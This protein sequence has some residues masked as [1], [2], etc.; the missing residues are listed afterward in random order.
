MIRDRIV[1]GLHDATL[2][3]KLQLEPELTLESAIAKVRQAEL[4]RKQQPVV[5]GDKPNIESVISRK[6][7]HSTR[8]TRDPSRL[9]TRNAPDKRWDVESCTR[10]GKVPGHNPQ[11][12]PAKL[13]TCHKCQKKG[14]FQKM[15]KTKKVEAVSTERN[16]EQVFLGAIESFSGKAWKVTLFVNDIPIQFKIDTGAEVSVIPEALSEPFSNILKPSNRTLSGP[17]KQEHHVCGQF[18]CSMRCDKES[19][20]Q[21]LYVVK[22]LDLA[23]V[24][25]PAIEA[26]NLV[27]KICNISTDKETIV[28]RFPKLFTGL[29]CLTEEYE[30][31]LSKDAVPHALTTPRRV[32]LPLLEPVKSELQRMEREGIITKVEGP[33]NWCAGMVV[34]P[35]PNHKV[36]I[37]VDLTHLNKSV[38]RE[39]HILPSVNHTLAQL[40]EAQFFTKLDANSGFWQVPLSKESARLTTFITPYG[41]FCFNRLPFGISSAPELFQRRMSTAL[42]GLEGV[43][44]LMDDI[45]I[46]GKTREEHD[47]RVLATLERLQKYGITLNKEKCSF[48]TDSVRFLGHIVRREG[49][50]ADPE[51]VR[52]I[53]DLAE[54]RN[55]IE[56]RRFLGM[57]NQLNKFS[58]LLTDTTKPMRDLLCSRNQWLWGETQPKAFMETKQL[59]SSTPIL[60]LYDQKRP[61]RVSA[62][63]SS[64]GL[65]A[66]LMQQ[67]SD[68]QWRPIAY[69]SRAMT[70]TEQR[71]AQV[72]KEA[73]AV[74][75]ACERFLHYLLGLPF[76]IE[77]D[78]KPLVSLLGNKPIDELPLRIQRFRMRMM[79]YTYSIF[80]VPGKNL[81]IADALSRAP[82][83]HL[84]SEDEEWN[85]EMNIYVETIFNTLPA[86]D[87]KIQQIQISQDKD[88]TCLLLKKYCLE[89]WPSKRNLEG[90]IQRYIPVADELSICEGLLLCNSRIVIPQ[91]LQSDILQKLHRGH[92]GIN[93]CKRRAALSVWWPGLN[94]D[95]ENMVSKCQACCKMQCQQVEPLIP[96]P[97]PT[98]PWQK[99]GVDFFEYRKASY[100]IV[101]DYFSRFI[102]IAK[103]TNTSATAVITQM[104]YIFARHGIPCCVMSDNGP[105]FSADVF[106]SFAKDYG[107]THYTSSSRFPQANGEV[108][109]GVRTV[110]TLLK[111]AEENSEDPYLALLEYRNTPLACGYSPAQ[112]TMCRNL[113]S[114]LPMTCEQ[115]NPKLP[116]MVV[117]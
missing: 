114:T 47:K 81:I 110:K 107:F 50:R 69:A 67:H 83:Q 71:Y 79:K 25:L 109:R 78:H 27:T 92:Q 21:E 24:G 38:Q 89:G 15:C 88:T 98:F 1:V 104:K 74:T 51:K 35:K 82:S 105:Q 85:K 3:E 48:S 23:L 49:V 42:E 2:S 30:I 87:T 115:L 93:K 61:T 63:A 73:L 54:P 97:L 22:G 116:D 6:Q 13:A 4:I 11:H 40:A 14:H 17:S 59:L 77:T 34:V 32:P 96:T 33:T 46:H 58:P 53:R 60:S 10:C 72:E 12:C 18:T 84:T 26:L 101:I 99:V 5:R 62:D 68:K 111:K 43:V 16:S 75:W 31:Q 100:V 94:K 80:H 64:F 44:C 113:R 91:A 70:P 86:S 52:G 117:F 28:S 76:E 90:E 9:P 39:R 8:R 102:E 55:L 95:L 45:L 37:C 36:R 112:L 57:C 29:G 20:R 106:S 108:E 65:G 7:I 19:T 66:V 103:L 56:L 41:R